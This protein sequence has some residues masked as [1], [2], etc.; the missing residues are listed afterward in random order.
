MKNPI[1][2]LSLLSFFFL[3]S[4]GNK[5]EFP[6]AEWN[7]NNNAKPVLFYISGD[8]G[9]NSFSK[10]FGQNMHRF[11]YDVFAL[12]TRKYF[13]TKRTPESA[14][15]DTEK[16]LKEITANRTNKKIIIVGF[17]Y[18]ADVAPFIYNRFDAGFK[19]NIQNLVII[20][21]SKVNDFEIH[22]AEYVTG[23]KEYG[24]SVLN[25]INNVRNVPFTLIVSDFEFY[26][27]PISQIMLKNYS[28]LHL[29]G[30]H[31]YGGDTKRLAA[32]VNANLNK[33]VKMEHGGN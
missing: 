26:H 2:I 18:G 14:A 30:D 31:H 22:L 10:N 11:G 4:C 19:K 32:F 17:S 12:N 8:A 20:G 7:S 21:P 28:L 9:F 13:W 5:N 15:E 23:E 6:V 16:F 29:H 3:I 25:E 1:K 24:F 33:K 27:F